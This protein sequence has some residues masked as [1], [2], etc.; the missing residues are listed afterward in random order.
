M[1]PNGP[2]VFI[3]QSLGFK[4]EGKENYLWRLEEEGSNTKHEL[5]PANYGKLQPIFLDH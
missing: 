1:E 5:K 2:K 4:E 3:R